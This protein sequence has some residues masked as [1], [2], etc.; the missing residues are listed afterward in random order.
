MAPEDTW[1]EMKDSTEEVKP[2]SG[3]HVKLY[4]GVALVAIAVLKTR[5]QCD[6]SFLCAYLV[7][8]VN[9]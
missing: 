4:A 3:G 2:R 5:L 8:A 1:A 7:F 6:V 9:L